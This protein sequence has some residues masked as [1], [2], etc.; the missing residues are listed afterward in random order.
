MTQKAEALR[1]V[2]DGLKDLD[3]PKGLVSSAVQKLTRAS[4]LLENKDVQIWCQIQ[5]AHS[6][7]VPELKNLM[8]V[9]GKDRP[10][11]DDSERDKEVSESLKKL[12]SIGLNQKYHYSNEEINVKF[13]EKGGGYASIG[14]I[15]ERYADLVRT[16]RGN[17][18][19][20]Y[21]INL[22]TH[23]AY[24]KNKAHEHLSLLH[25][26]LKF[27][28][29]VTN[30]FDLLKAAVDDKL[31]DLNP[32]LAEQLMIAFRSV[33]GA[34]S[35]EWSQ[36]LTSCRRLLEGIADELFPAG[37]SNAKGR[38]LGQGQYVNRLWAFMDAA[39]ESES[40]RDLAKSHVDYLG[41]WLER[42]NRI[43][44]KGVHADVTQLEAVKAVFH[45]YLAIADLLE[46]MTATSKPSASRD[47]NDAT[48]DE[49][50]A[51]L[52][53]SR[54]TAKEIIKARVLNGKLDKV[55]LAKVKGVGAKVL[56]KAVEIFALDK[57]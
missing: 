30:S 10:K 12:E 54:A 38:P 11:G 20:Y 5:M 23:I 44:N 6:D 43:A 29:T 48:I 46:Y 14:F 4:A 24:I 16:K 2:E 52:D 33:S 36:A 25:N 27:S 1:L 31:L 42:T 53:I 40:N 41:S 39:I 7:Y 9:L 17:D 18:G 15:E 19:S 21:K 49:L 56:A 13:N 8:K 45:T 32:V 50:E 51:L 22:S 55:S 3:S 26:Q 35:E 57:S 37:Q 28:G 47:I 34:N